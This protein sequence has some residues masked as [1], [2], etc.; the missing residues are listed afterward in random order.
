ML[1][2]TFL[3]ACYTVWIAG[4]A[5]V[6][7]LAASIHGKVLHVFIKITQTGRLFSM[8]QNKAPAYVHRGWQLKIGACP[9]PGIRSASVAVVMVATAVAPVPLP[10]MVTVGCLV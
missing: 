4:S 3:C 1:G 8:L 9:W 6:P 2:N 7:P 10:A 5:F